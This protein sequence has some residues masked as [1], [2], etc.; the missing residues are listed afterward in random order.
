MKSDV[1]FITD[2]NRLRPENSEVFRLCC[3]NSKIQNLTGFKPKYTLEQGLKATID[4]FSR[5]QN[6]V[7]YKADIYNV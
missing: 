5:S 7:H 1:E 6:K 4:W 3:D 2:Q